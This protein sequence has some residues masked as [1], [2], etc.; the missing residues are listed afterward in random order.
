MAFFR[1]LTPSRSIA[2]LVSALACLLTAVPLAAQD[3]GTIVEKLD[4]AMRSATFV[5]EFNTSADLAPFARDF[6]RNIATAFESLPANVANASRIGFVL[7]RAGTREQWQFELIKPMPVKDAMRALAD[8]ATS[9]VFDDR[10]TKTWPHL[11][12]LYIAQHAYPWA[13]TPLQKRVIISWL[14]DDAYPKTIGVRAP[15][16]PSGIDAAASGRDLKTDNITV[17][18]VETRPSGSK[19]A[20]RLFETVTEA[21]SGTFI[22]WGKGGEDLA[23]RITGAIAAQLS[24]SRR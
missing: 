13:E 21:S 7:S 16:V 17:I 23:A 9:D 6:A 12:A 19:Q 24:S 15:S 4:V 20:Q 3:R 2:I 5:I 14:N 1:R 10:D 22:D 8:A 11:D 18:A